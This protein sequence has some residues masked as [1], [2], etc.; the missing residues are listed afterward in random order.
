MKMADYLK[1]ERMLLLQFNGLPLQIRLML[2]NAYDEQIR[3][4]ESDQTETSGEEQELIATM[5]ELVHEY[6]DA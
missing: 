3:L 1:M 5:E 4:V 6:Q 2:R